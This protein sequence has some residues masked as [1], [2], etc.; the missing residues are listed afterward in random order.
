[1]LPNPDRS[2]IVRLTIVAACAALVAT[3]PDARAAQSRAFV[4][5][6][7]FE[8]GKVSVAQFGPPRTIATNVATVHSD[9]V[10]RWFDGLLYVVNRGA[11]NVQVLDPAAAFATLRQFGVGDN[12]NPH[13]IV[14]ASPTKAYVTRYDSSDLWIVNPQT[15]AHTGTISLAGFADGDAIPEMDHMAIQAGRLF[16]SI[17]RLDRFNFYAPVGGSL[18]AVIDPVTDVLLDLDPGTSG[19]QGIPLPRQNPLTEISLDSAGRLVVG[20]SGAFGALDGG[21]VRVHPGTFAIEAVEITEAA[22][23][24]DLGDVAPYDGQ[25]GYAVIGDAEFNTVL[26]SYDRVT[27]SV[28]GT[29][30]STA[31]FNIADIEVNDRAELWVCDR[32]PG[33]P[34]LRV[35][36]AA[37]GAQL[38]ASPLLS[39]LPP[40]DIEF[41]ALVPTDVSLRPVAADLALRVSA[42]RPN[43]ARGEATIEF[44]VGRAL[45]AGA[46]RATLSTY[47]LAGRLVRRI[48]R[49]VEGSGAQRWRWDGIDGSGRSLS[50]GVYS[51]ELKVGSAVARS[52]LVVVR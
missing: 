23:G 49:A 34:G 48:E 8:T 19:T 12:A 31:G 26:R 30:F 33:A 43:P 3:A 46:A 4:C 50:P 16:V 13:D 45:A 35:F 36:D 6:T 51:L 37:T 25:R 42:V 39:G 7:D 5:T 41:D 22:L 15:G 9:A 32:S 21:V 14:F 52:R 10:L 11:N 28:T 20:C 2:A 38:T 27:G 24:G 1:M 29:P 40:Q 18:L 44:E 47:D 17:Q